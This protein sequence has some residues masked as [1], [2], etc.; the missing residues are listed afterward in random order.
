MDSYVL[1]AFATLKNGVTSHSYLENK[2]DIFINPFHATNI[3]LYS[4]KALEN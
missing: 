3:F 4:Y 2:V 1:H